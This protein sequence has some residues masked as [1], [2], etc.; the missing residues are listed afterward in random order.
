MIIT[1]H[2]NVLKVNHLYKQSAIR[3]FYGLGL[4]YVRNAHG[5]GSVFRQS[6]GTRMKGCVS[7]SPALLSLTCI[8]SDS[9]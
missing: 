8:Q 7:F 6:A 2:S 1:L 4:Q 9:E 3:S 5:T